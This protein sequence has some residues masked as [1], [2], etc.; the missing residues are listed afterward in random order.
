M[1]ELHWKIYILP[2]CFVCTPDHKTMLRLLSNEFTKHADWH[3]R[4]LNFRSNVC[5]LTTIFSCIIR[6]T[7]SNRDRNVKTPSYKFPSDKISKPL[8]DI[9]T[10]YW[11]A[12]VSQRL[13]KQS[14]DGLRK[15]SSGPCCPIKDY[16]L[17]SLTAVY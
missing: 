11:E 12:G 15:T 1:D 13:M 10:L 5:G 3:G 9:F 16:F 7:R 8:V 6:V 14:D 17:Y 2:K 4:K